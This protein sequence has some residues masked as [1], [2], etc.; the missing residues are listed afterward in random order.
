MTPTQGGGWTEKVLYNFGHGTDA[1]YPSAGLIFDAAGNLYGTTTFG[2]P[3]GAGTIFEL[4][5]TGGGGW[6]EHV[7]YNLGSLA[8][9]IYPYA[10]VIFDK[11]GNLYGTTSTGG[12]SSGGTVFTLTPSG[13]GGWTKTVLHNFGSGTDGATPYS[14]LI[15]DAA[16]NLYGTTS[17]GGAYTSFGT[18]FELTPGQGGSWTEQVV[19]SFGSGEDAA[20]PYAGLIS[21]LAGNLYGTTLSGGAY[22]E[23]TVFRYNAQGELVLHS[24][25]SSGDGSGPVASLV[26][27]AVGNLYGTTEYGGS[28]FDGAVFEVTPPTALKFIAVAPC[29]VVD[30]RLANGLFGGPAITGGSFRSFPLPQGACDIPANAAAYS[31][32]VTVIPIGTLGYL[33]IWPTGQGQPLVSTMNSLDGRI[34]ANAAIVPGGTLG[35]VSVFVSN[36]TDVALDI[37]G[38]FAATGSSTLQFYPLT[39]CRVLDTRDPTGTLG[40]PYLASVPN[41]TSPCCPVAA[42]FPA[43]R[44]R[45][46]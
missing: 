43:P 29:R 11:N 34:K 31:L 41:G 39:P 17:A 30:T 46:P 35:A 32:N 22:D 37:D 7:L 40:G 6:S 10:G 14:G 2:G 36:T 38:Y 12:T 20:T 3:A 23:G 19:H 1:A 5:P 25:G 33:T 26:F 45:T 16:G 8:A 28:H 9:G 18:I 4:T 24:F 42:T 13:G 21:D 44:N 27:D 15:F